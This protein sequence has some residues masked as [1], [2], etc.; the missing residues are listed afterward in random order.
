MYTLHSNQLA[1]S[2]LLSNFARKHN[3]YYFVD[4]NTLEFMISKRMYDQLKVLVE[5]QAMVS[6]ATDAKGRF[7]LS[8]RET[9]GE[10]ILNDDSKLFKGFKAVA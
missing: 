7:G 3:F 9:T 1:S 10:P 6:I 4:E 2:K 5:S 8:P